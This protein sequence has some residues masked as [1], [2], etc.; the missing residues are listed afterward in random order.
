MN[1]KMYRLPKVTSGEFLGLMEAY[2]IS[3]MHLGL[4]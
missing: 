2:N 4:D 1:N 3:R